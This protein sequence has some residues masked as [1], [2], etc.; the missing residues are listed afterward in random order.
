[1]I[2]LAA[3]ALLPVYQRLQYH[4]DY[5][6]RRATLSH[7][8]Y[9]N[10]LIGLQWNPAL[11]A[12]YGL[13]DVGTDLGA[14]RAVEAFYDAS[15]HS[16]LR[17][18]SATGIN[19]VTTQMPFDFV[20]YEEAARALYLK[21]WREEPMEVLLAVFYWHP[22]DIYNVVRLYAGFTFHPRFDLQHAYNP[23]RPVYLGVLLLTV[24]LCSGGGT[25]LRPGYALMALIML[26]SSLLVPLA[27]Y[28][29]GFVILAE[30]FVMTSLVTYATM[31]VLLAHAFARWRQRFAQ[32]EAVVEGASA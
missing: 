6:G 19:A 4:P 20:A 28:A 26:A 3:L 18:W 21:I 14:A 13:G 12:R 30:F 11:A 2:L 27:F 29:G 5:F 10:L 17:T 1:V 32:R 7:V 22:R 16:E 9:H 23:F 15:G 31:A 24:A 8:V 25:P